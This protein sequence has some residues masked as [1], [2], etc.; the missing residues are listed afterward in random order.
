LAVQKI[1]RQSMSA[2]T[3]S[4]ATASLPHDSQSDDDCRAP[5][6]LGQAGLGAGADPDRA[7]CRSVLE[8]LENAVAACEAD[9]SRDHTI[10]ISVQGLPGT[11]I[12]Q[13][14]VSDD[15]PGFGTA[16]DAIGDRGVSAGLGLATVIRWAVSTYWWGGGCGSHPGPDELAE[17]LSVA[18]GQLRRR[19]WGAAHHADAAEPAS[20]T[21]PPQLLEDYDGSGSH[22]SA[23]LLGGRK[24]IDVLRDA[25]AY[26]AQALCT[27]SSLTIELDVATS[28][29][30]AGARS[31]T[32]RHQ[33]EPVVMSRM[34]VQAGP[35][36]SLPG[37]EQLLHSLQDELRDC[38]VVPAAET[39]LGA[40]SESQGGPPAAES[41]RVIA[42][43][44]AGRGVLSGS[45][46]AHATLQLAVEPRAPSAEQPRSRSGADSSTAPLHVLVLLNNKRLD[47]ADQQQFVAGCACFDAIKR[48]RGWKKHLGSSLTSP[49]DGGLRVGSEG[50]DAVRC[51]WLCLHLRSPNVH[52]SDASRRR[53]MPA[54]HLPSAINAALDGALTQ[55]CAR[56]APHGV[57]LSR[58][59][60]RLQEARAYAAHIATAMADILNLAAQQPGREMGEGSSCA[61]LEREL[62]Q[63]LRLA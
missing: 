11:N 22:V 63:L 62:M 16:L 23:L 61:T 54:K 7:L 60:Q 32:V 49:G 46:F 45:G 42:A 34:F 48:A 5:P 10:K 25:I 57:K 41:G 17:I 33:V 59:E 40:E 2:S 18:R 19:T 27:T 28:H 30:E 6:L 9:D 36:P 8:L 1:S 53:I 3:A 52:F 39:T 55:V 47:L 15:G 43:H 31:Y 20:V 4:Q 44:G 12:Y 21:A 50:D 56:L 35:A 38:V 51:G 37:V 14:C 29:G 24:A 13:V 58:A 26:S